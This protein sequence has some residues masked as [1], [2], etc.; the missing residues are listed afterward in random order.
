MIENADARSKS[1]QWPRFHLLVGVLTLLVGTYIFIQFLEWSE[2]DTIEAKYD[3]IQLGMNVHDVESLFGPPLH[4]S[5]YLDGSGGEL[6][7]KFEDDRSFFALYAA[8]GTV[9][10]KGWYNSQGKRKSSLGDSIKRFLR[11][12]GL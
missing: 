9:T 7:W 1:I 2:N 6:I 11:K 3:R 10:R 4:S 5:P 8:D 12:L